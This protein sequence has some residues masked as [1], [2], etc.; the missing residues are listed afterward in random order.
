MCVIV[1]KFI[2]GLITVECVKVYY[3][4]KYKSFWPYFLFFIGSLTQLSYS[5]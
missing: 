4:K 3:W 1:V 2:Y 5:V